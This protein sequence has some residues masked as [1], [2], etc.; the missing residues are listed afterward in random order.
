MNISIPTASVFLLKAATGR[1]GRESSFCFS[2]L[3]GFLGLR[4]ITKWRCVIL[5]VV[6]QA[7][8]GVCAGEDEG[9]QTVAELRQLGVH[10]FKDATSGAVTEVAANGNR[11]ITDD[12]MEVLA[13][14]AEL[15][16]ISLERTRVGSEGMRQLKVLKK[17]V[18]HLS[19]MKNLKLLPVGNSGVTDAGLVHLGRMA[20]L[21]YLGLRGNTI[22]GKGMIH[23][24]QLK[25]IKGLHLGET[26]VDDEGIK[27][28]AGLVY[29]ERLWLHDTRV[30]DGSIDRITKFSR[31][32]EIDL[33]N[34]AV[35]AEG[36]ARL[37]DLLP[38]CKVLHSS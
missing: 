11:A 8:R 28:L 16:D 7:C 3:L 17:L 37:R 14:F 18:E 12:H 21:E 23:L 24:A 27:H 29:L 5:F 2:D 20:Q 25:K 32:R 4:G 30:T 34:T 15:T 22:T 13:S 35:S 33:R 1:R 31:L 36:V 38:K 9:R 6:C 10:V 26:K 19:V